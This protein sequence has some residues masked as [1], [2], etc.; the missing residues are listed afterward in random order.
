M[1]DKQIKLLEI[2]RS[3][4]GTPY[5]YAAK[6]EEVP[7]V[8]DCSSFTQHIYKQ[9]GI[10]LKRS[11]ILQATQGKV[12]PSIEN[13]EVGDLMFFRGSKGHYNDELFP[14]EEIYIGHVAMYTGNGK[15]IHAASGKG[16]IEE[17][18]KEITKKIYPIVM[19][20]RVL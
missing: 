12:V 2:A 6:A 14:N 7:S 5:K 15:A 20:K 17:N 8:I 3:L 9:I 13:A 18:I 11:T 19:I 10:D 4:I 1:N 16:V